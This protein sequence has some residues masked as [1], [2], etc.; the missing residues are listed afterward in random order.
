MTHLRL[1]KS[2]EPI[3][4]C[5]G[6]CDSGRQ[7]CPHPQACVLPDDSGTSPGFRLFLIAFA[8]VAACVGVVVI[9]SNN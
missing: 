5:G 6:S 1:V 7:P 9:C 2:A 4:S 8:V 3:P